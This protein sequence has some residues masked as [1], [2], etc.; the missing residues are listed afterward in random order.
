MKGLKV[1]F[2][3]FSL[4]VVI[5]LYIFN[6]HGDISSNVHKGI[7]LPI[8][9]T[10]SSEVSVHFLKTGYI[11]VPE[12][13][14]I[15]QGSLFDKFEM[16]HGAILVQHG[17][18]SFLFDTGLGKKID[19]QFEVDMPFWLKPF[20]SYEKDKAAVDIINKNSNLLIP[21]RIFLSHSHWDH[22]SGLVDF[23]N[24][25]IWISAQEH[26][27]LQSAKP[28]SVFPSQVKSHIIQWQSYQLNNG[29]YAGF[30]KSYD[31]FGDGTAVIVDLSGHSAGSVGL[32]VDD[33]KG[34]RR[35]FV[36]DAVWNLDAVKNL[37]RKSWAASLILDHD[38][39]ATD[40]TIAK[41]HALMNANPE[42]IIIPAH[43]LSTWQ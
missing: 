43:D 11:S 24:A 2:L 5:F 35:F 38:E 36:G 22:A 37:K 32:F 7:K 19:E 31:I 25:K 6:I 29:S 3:F 12:A 8:I 28:P 14:S 13:F 21:S 1:L 27:Y 9:S 15:A 30:S 10:A 42:L 33:K 20:M 4:I 18:E 17:S 26:D 23:P 41:L 34:I 16:V 40:N 39:Q